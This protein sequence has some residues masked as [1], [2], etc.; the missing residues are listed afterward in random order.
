MNDKERKAYDTAVRFEE[1]TQRLATVLREGASEFSVARPE[2]TLS[3]PALCGAH[4]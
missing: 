4:S 3:R 1:G 2:Q